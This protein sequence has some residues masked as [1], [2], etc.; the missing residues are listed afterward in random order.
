M[1]LF[2]RVGGL[3]YLGA[4]TPFNVLTS[5]GNIGFPKPVCGKVMIGESDGEKRSA[6]F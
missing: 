2:H 3:Q 4:A 5:F 1:L 6:H